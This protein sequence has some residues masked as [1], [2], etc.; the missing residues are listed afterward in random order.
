MPLP[1]Y[2][3]NATESAPGGGAIEQWSAAQTVVV[4]PDAGSVV[5]RPKDLMRGPR[6]GGMRL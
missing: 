3:L 1:G 2:N 6:D 5:G 4:Q